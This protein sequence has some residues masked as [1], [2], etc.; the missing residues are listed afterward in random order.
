MPTYICQ[1]SLQ[2]L[3]IIIFTLLYKFVGN[4]GSSHS[5]P[6]SGVGATLTRPS[7]D[8]S[9]SE[10]WMTGRS[11]EETSSSSSHGSSSA[12]VGFCPSRPFPLSLVSP[13]S[14]VE[15]ASP[16]PYSVASACSRNVSSKS[17]HARIGA[18][19]S[20]FFKASQASSCF[21]THS[22]IQSFLRN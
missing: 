16:I 20:K 5:I 17:G 8:T 11:P 18:T 22:H 7:W 15:V 14:Q 13:R 1:M 12:A 4:Q 6:N 9:L 2:S 19:V 21:D 3:P 10:I